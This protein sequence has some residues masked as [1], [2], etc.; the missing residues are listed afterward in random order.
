MH[1]LS[2][3]AGISSDGLRTLSQFRDD[4]S[5]YTPQHVQLD[6]DW[7][8]NLSYRAF[9]LASRSSNRLVIVL[10]VSGM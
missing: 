5:R 2:G 9:I 4:M 1:K 10:S 3:E 8:Q 6:I 7:I